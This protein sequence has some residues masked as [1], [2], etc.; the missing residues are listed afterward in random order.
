V[1]LLAHLAVTTVRDGIL[2]STVVHIMIYGN[3]TIAGTPADLE[4]AI[5]PLTHGRPVVLEFDSVAGGPAG[6]EST[7]WRRTFGD[8]PVGT[9]LL[10]ADSEGNLALADNQGDAAARLG[11]AV[12]QR[13]RIRPV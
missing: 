12:G 9:S 10:Y 8:V 3:L 4:A 6:V 2:E 1:I 7:T 5:G 13:V 11:L